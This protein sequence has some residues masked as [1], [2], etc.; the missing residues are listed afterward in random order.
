MKGFAI[1][2]LDGDKLKPRT[3]YTVRKGGNGFGINENEVCYTLSCVDRH[4][5]GICALSKLERGGALVKEG[6][7][8][9]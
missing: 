4:M 5:V 9:D 2:A 7:F 6:L 3:D 8:C 1:Y